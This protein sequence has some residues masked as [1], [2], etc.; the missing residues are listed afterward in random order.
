MSAPPM[1]ALFS[2]LTTSNLRSKSKYLISG[3][4]IFCAMEILDD[5]ETSQKKLSAKYQT[6][7]SEICRYLH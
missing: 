1:Q 7:V 2:S 4:C 6:G 3:K 5:Y